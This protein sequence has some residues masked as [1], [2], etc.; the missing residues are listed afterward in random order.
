[1]QQVTD[2][3]EHSAGGADHVLEVGRD[4]Q[5]LHRL[6]QAARARSQLSVQS[7]RRDWDE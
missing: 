2:H 5:V 7:W 1:V 3:R 6:P 4:A